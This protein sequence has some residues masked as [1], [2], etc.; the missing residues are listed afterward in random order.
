VRIQT[1]VG[2]AQATSSTTKKMPKLIPS[3]WMPVK[4]PEKVGSPHKPHHCVS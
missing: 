4:S 2:D 1:K 3:K